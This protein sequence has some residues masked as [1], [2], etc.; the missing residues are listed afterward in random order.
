MI[1]QKIL[2]IWP[3][4]SVPDCPNKCASGSVLFEGIENK[5]DLTKCY[6]HAVY[7]FLVDPEQIKEDRAKGLVP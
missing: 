3:N 1:P 5:Y 7:G 4:C 2:D 6:P